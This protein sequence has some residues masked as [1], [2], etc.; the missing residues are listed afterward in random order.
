M[1]GSPRRAYSKTQTRVV[2]RH[3]RRRLAHVSEGQL[4]SEE[5]PAS[6]QAFYEYVSAVRI[7]ELADDP[8]AETESAVM[9]RGNQPL[10]RLE[11]AA[12]GFAGNSDT[13][14]RTDKDAC[15][16]AFSITSSIGP[17]APYFSAL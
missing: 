4:N 6:G 3:H 2:S 13:V 17:P 14:S 9:V 15:S 12:L 8:Q 16:G 1:E 7:D 10:E 11:N 5:R